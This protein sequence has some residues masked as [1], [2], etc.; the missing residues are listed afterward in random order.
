MI[1]IGK[2]I[3]VDPVVEEL[4][5]S[6]GMLLTDETTLRYKKG[7]VVE[8]GT[9]VDSVNSG[10]QIFYDKNA[11]HSIMIN[12]EIYLIILERDVVVVL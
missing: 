1:A 9:L 12:D 4:K 5:T 11:G 10:D 6:S 7:V 2:Y 8:P 3:I